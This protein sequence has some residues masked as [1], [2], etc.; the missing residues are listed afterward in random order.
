M[1]QIYQPCLFL[2]FLIDVRFR[3]FVTDNLMFYS[4]GD[5]Y[6]QKFKI[7]EICIINDILISYRSML[8]QDVYNLGHCA[9]KIL[10]CY[11]CEINSSQSFH[12]IKQ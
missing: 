11:L 1:I 4:K 10:L 5:C 8:I 3:N 6:F 12:I 9:S 2:Q 7:V